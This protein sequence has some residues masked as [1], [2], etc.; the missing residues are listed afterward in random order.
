MKITLDRS[1]NAAYISF[2]EKF[3]DD[4]PVRTY[5]CDP[6]EVG[7]E[8]NIDFDSA[9][10]LVGIEVLDATRLLPADLLQVAEIIS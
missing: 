1:I 3:G 6:N 4:C 7:G 5:P 8:I 2:A 9:G 10:Q